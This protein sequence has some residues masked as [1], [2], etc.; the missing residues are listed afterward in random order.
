MHKKHYEESFTSCMRNTRQLALDQQRRRTLI[1]I[2]FVALLFEV[3]VWWVDYI[4]MG[5]VYVDITK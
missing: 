2:E 4:V 3:V 1:S 5:D